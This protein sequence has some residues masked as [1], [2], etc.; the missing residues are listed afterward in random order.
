MKQPVEPKILVETNEIDVSKAAMQDDKKVVLP[1]VAEK[2]ERKRKAALE[3]KR[4]RRLKFMLAIVI[5]V[6]H[7]AVVVYHHNRHEQLFEMKLNRGLLLKNHHLPYIK[8]AMAISGTILAFYYMAIYNCKTKQIS[9]TTLT[10]LGLTI[11]LWVARLLVLQPA[12]FIAS[13]QPLDLFMLFG[14]IAVLIPMILLWGGP[15]ALL[16][17]E[18]DKERLLNMMQQ[19]FEKMVNDAEAVNTAEDE[20]IKSQY[21]ELLA[22]IDKEMEEEAAEKKKKRKAKK[23]KPE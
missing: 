23:K 11:L 21:N 6:Y 20:A 19:Q 18:K 15:E 9:I 4:L 14:T 5:A 7:V 3:R 8:H 16:F 10:M 22:Q 12:Y 13:R 17:N 2:R 1:E